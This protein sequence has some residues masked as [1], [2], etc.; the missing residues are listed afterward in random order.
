MNATRVPIYN[1]IA[2]ASRWRYDLAIRHLDDTPFEHAHG[3]RSRTCFPHGVIGQSWDDDD[4]GV[5]GL[6]DDYTYNA[7]FPVVVTSAN[8]QAL[9][10]ERAPASVVRH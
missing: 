8:A 10:T 3:R 2:G 6:M 7:S 1:F 9:E 5:D 4:L